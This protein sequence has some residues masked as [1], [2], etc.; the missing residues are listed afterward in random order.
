MPTSEF[1]LRK[2]LLKKDQVYNWFDRYEETQNK[3]IYLL[4]QEV[5][6]CEKLERSEKSRTLNKFKHK[7]RFAARP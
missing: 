4:N 1:M 3:E 7:L 6:K 2:K 5:V